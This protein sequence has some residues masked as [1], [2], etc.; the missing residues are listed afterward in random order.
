[1]RIK[2]QLAF[3]QHKK[4]NSI[5]RSQDKIK[6]SNNNNS[7][8][9]FYKITS[10][11]FNASEIMAQS[12][13]KKNFANKQNGISNSESIGLLCQSQDKRFINKNLDNK[14]KF[15][16]SNVNHFQRNTNNNLK[17]YSNSN[18]KSENSL[19]LDNIKNKYYLKINNT[20]NGA[21][22]SYSLPKIKIMKNPMQISLD[23]EEKKFIGKKANSQRNILNFSNSTKSKIIYKLKDR[24]IIPNKY[25]EEISLAEILNEN[26]SYY[27][28]AKHSENSF[29]KIISYGVNTYRGV[30]RNYNEDRVTIL[31]N[32]LVNKGNKDT[33]KYLKNLKIS[34]FSI[35]DGHAGNKCCEFL[36]KF[37]HHYIF[38]S[39]F[40]PLNPIKAIEDGFNICENKFMSLIYSDNKYID[41]SG[42]CALVLLILNDICYIANLGDSRALYSCN[43]GKKF[44]QISRDHK[45]NDPIEKNRIYKFGGSIYKQTNNS[46]QKKEAYGSQQMER[47][48]K[49]PFRINPGRLAVSY[50]YH[51][52]GF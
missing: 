27:Q 14:K 46:P 13:N 45:P 24:A 31:I 23:K 22:N 37:L 47:M 19:L 16:L 2:T 52:L 18:H 21:Q 40:F 12:T 35:Y 25:S 36:K 4:P 38:E 34:Y 15:L 26:Y 3:F 50:F 51:Y 9:N 8:L 1:M 29:D 49:I 17:N 33:Q 44:F 39:E 11:F 28:R 20:H 5:R 10:K 7:T 41:P 6:K 43:D 30:I 42:S 48:A 32:A